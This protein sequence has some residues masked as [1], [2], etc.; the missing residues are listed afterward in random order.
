MSAEY[1]DEYGAYERANFDDNYGGPK[2]L[3]E[4]R[5]QTPLERF[6]DECANFLASKDLTE[7]REFILEQASKLQHV[8]F[9]NVAGYCLGFYCLSGNAVDK[10]RFQKVAG[11][12]A[13]TIRSVDL[14]RYAFLWGNLLR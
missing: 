8:R 14:L 3:Q 7:Q 5:N 13:D 6:Q 10:E 9:K 12:H 11:Q 2:T 1:G 4:L